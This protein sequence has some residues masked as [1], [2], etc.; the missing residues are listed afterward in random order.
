[1][2]SIGRQDLMSA[3]TAPNEIVD[4]VENDSISQNDPSSKDVCAASRDGDDHSV[5]AHESPPAASGHGADLQ[6]S[7]P[8]SR[9]DSPDITS[10]SDAAPLSPAP[11]EPRRAAAATDDSTGALR[12]GGSHT[13][14]KLARGVLAISDMAV[15]AVSNAATAATSAIT[16]YTETATAATPPLSQPLRVSSAYAHRR[17]HDDSCQVNA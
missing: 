9:G 1:M 10:L 12:R 3:V 6:A 17:A 16:S 14:E 11:V 15:A 2:T 7:K 13:A 4:M 8:G 5:R